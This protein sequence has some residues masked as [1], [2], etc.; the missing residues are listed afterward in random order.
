MQH[1]IRQK[2]V[3]KHGQTFVTSDFRA[4]RLRWGLQLV[5]SYTE[6]NESTNLHYFGLLPILL[7]G[8]SSIPA[9]TTERGRELFIAPVA[10]CRYITSRFKNFLIKFRCLRLP[11][12]SV[13][14]GNSQFAAPRQWN[15]ATSKLDHLFCLLS[16]MDSWKRERLSKHLR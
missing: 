2:R 13:I 9:L 14:T 3:C 10:V 1:A 6:R 5:V 11:T 4:R 15:G 12:N 7:F 16:N 8:S